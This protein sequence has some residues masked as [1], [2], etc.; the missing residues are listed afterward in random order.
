[1]TIRENIIRDKADPIAMAPKEPVEK[2]ISN[3]RPTSDKNTKIATFNGDI[4]KYPI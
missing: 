3:N 1:M 4:T 2:I